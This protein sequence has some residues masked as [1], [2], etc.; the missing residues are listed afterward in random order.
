MRVASTDAI[1]DPAAST[2]AASAST[3]ASP[4]RAQSDRSEAASR[5]ASAAA[6]VSSRSS[7]VNASA[8]AIHA[9]APDAAIVATVLCLV[10][11][12]RASPSRIASASATHRLD[13]LEPRSSASSAL[14]A[15]R[16][17]DAASRCA[18]LEMLVRSSPTVNA[19][20]NP[21][22]APRSRNGT[23]GLDAASDAA[24]APAAISASRSLGFDAAALHRCSSA[25]N[26]V[27]G[28]ALVFLEASATSWL[29]SFTTAHT[30]GSMSAGHAS[31]SSSPLPFF[32]GGIAGSRVPG[33]APPRA[34]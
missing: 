8:S 26:R 12:W 9:R 24:S 4:N 10:L 1:A 23:S 15:T 17:S 33:G 7:S 14:A 2:T 25:S 29:T 5:D 21:R 30:S 3:A 18:A 34:R 27:T 16:A 20:V 32:L 19:R 28:G 11:A 13:V 22:P 31:A 6:T